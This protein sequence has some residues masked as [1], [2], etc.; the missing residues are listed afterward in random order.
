MEL[1]GHKHVRR[2]PCRSP[3][4]PL[5][6]RRGLRG[7][8][9]ILGP[10]RVRRTLP[11]APWSAPPRAP[12]LPALPLPTQPPGPPGRPRPP[13]WQGRRLRRRRG[14]GPR[15]SCWRRP[16]PMLVLELVLVAGR[17][18]LVLALVVVRGKGWAPL[19]LPQRLQLLAPV[20]APPRR[21]LPWVAA[22]WRRARPPGGG[23]RRGSCAPR[24]AAHP[25]PWTLRASSRAGRDAAA[26]R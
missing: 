23:Q 19:A 22:P 14:P 18:L 12:T 13:G 25:A 3:S 6:A 1:A 17:P 2:L 9:A 24:P 11:P 21:S 20:T 10:H 8:G 15:A 26:P 5:I 4:W 16:D 7:C